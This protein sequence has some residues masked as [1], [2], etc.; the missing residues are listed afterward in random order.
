MVFLESL[1]TLRH[2]S[3]GAKGFLP[4]RLLGIHLLESAPK[5]GSEKAGGDFRATYTHSL[6]VTP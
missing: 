2:V 4:S 6:V 3:Q 1:R 5:A